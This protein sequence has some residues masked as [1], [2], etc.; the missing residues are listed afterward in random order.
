MSVALARQ[1]P[2]P[3][4]VQQRRC[5]KCGK[6]VSRAAYACRRCGKSQRIRPK[7]MLLLASIGLMAAMF[8]VAILS[9]SGV[10]VRPPIETAPVP[11]AAA[12]VPAGP[13][14]P[15]FASGQ[16]PELTAGELWSAYTRDPAAADRQ[17]RQHSLQV[18]GTVRSIDRNFEGD[19]VVRLATPDA[20]DSVNA[21]VATRNDP[22]L[23]TLAKG[24]S[25]SLLCVGHGAMMGAP[26]LAG[27]F[28]R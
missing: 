5:G 12:A 27:C 13:L 2:Y 6:L 11:A 26:L 18:T 9:A 1:P 23:A 15:R 25:V 8:T 3:V 16:T 22:A 19:M 7:T 10:S 28:V 14:A 24:R 21:T 20:F 17:Y 4:R